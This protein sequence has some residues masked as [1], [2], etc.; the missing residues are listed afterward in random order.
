MGLD[1]C[2]SE[3]ESDAQCV[4]FVMW[5]DQQ[6]EYA[7]TSSSCRAGCTKHNVG[8]VGAI[9]LTTGP[10]VG[11]SGCYVKEVAPPTPAQPIPANATPAKAT[12]ENALDKQPP[13]LLPAKTLSPRDSAFY[14]EGSHLSR[15]IS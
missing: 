10:G 14:D 3:C 4:G 9:V 8:R 15:A 12:A 6:C 5:L 1:V 7:T 2:H 11:Y 13:Q